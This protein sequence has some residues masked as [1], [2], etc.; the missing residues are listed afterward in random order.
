MRDEWEGLKNG[1]PWVEIQGLPKHTP[2]GYHY[3]RGAEDECHYKGCAIMYWLRHL[4]KQP[5]L[6]FCP[7]CDNPWDEC[8]G[9]FEWVCMILGLNNVI[10]E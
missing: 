7:D 9:S 8:I 5:V 2:A 4:M 3:C 1:C 6:K 10:L